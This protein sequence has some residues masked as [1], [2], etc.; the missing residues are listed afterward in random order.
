MPVIMDDANTE[1][2][3]TLSSSINLATAV[4]LHPDAKVFTLKFVTNAGLFSHGGTEDNVSILA[5]GYPI[6]ADSDAE[7]ETLAKRILKYRRDIGYTVL[8]DQPTSGELVTFSDGVN[9]VIFGFGAGGDVQVVI[10]ADRDATLANLVTALNVSAV[11]IRT[12]IH[13]KI[14]DRL[15]YMS[16]VYGETI[17]VTPGD[18]DIT[19][20]PLGDK[21]QIIFLASGVGATVAHVLTRGA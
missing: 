19:T 14:A 20:I 4:A 17:T 8:N 2:A 1:I 13:P 3:I 12:S 6:A 18:G 15:D 9:T 16:T 10:G 11:N 7:E 5:Q 21:R